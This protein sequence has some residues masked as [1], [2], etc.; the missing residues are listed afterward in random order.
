MPDY[1][2]LNTQITAVKQEITDS[3]AASTYTAQDLVFIASALDKLGAMLGVNDIVN[4][5]ADRIT[6]INTAASTTVI[7][8]STTAR[9]L[10]T[11]TD[12]GNVVWCTSGSDTTITVP[13][14][15]AQAF[16]TGTVVEIVQAGSG[17]VT[18]S[19]SAG[20]TLSYPD[21]ANKTRVQYSAATLLK[22]ATDQWLLNGDLTF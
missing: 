9:T 15:A 17:Q 22:V 16:P 12:G 11:A 8:E 5:T 10:S 13:T 6:A 14:N 3:L 20:V 21:N 2:S 19:P 18:I 1:S 4:A 7:T